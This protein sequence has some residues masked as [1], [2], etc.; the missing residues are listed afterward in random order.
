M[1]KLALILFITLLMVTNYS[2]VFAEEPSDNSVNFEV[3]YAETK[4]GNLILDGYLYNISNVNVD[5]ITKLDVNYVDSDGGVVGEGSFDESNFTNIKLKPGQA[6]EKQLTVK[7]LKEIDE[8]LDYE[9]NTTIEYDYYESDTKIGPGIK[10]YYNGEKI[11]FPTQPVVDNGRTLVPVRG[12][13]EKMG[14]TVTY[15]AATKTVT[16]KRDEVE[17]KLTVGQDKAYVYGE[18][19]KLDTPAKIVNGSTL[20]PLR[21]ISEAFGAA[22]EWEPTTSMIGLFE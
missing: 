4:D 9:Y 21:F 6:V 18:E 20:V 14:A 1:K 17:V 22:I 19:V 3:T 15:D 12:I 2:F 11:D 13:F 5:K 10:V 8:N 7:A 16:A